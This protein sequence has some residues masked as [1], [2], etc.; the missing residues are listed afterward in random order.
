MTRVLRRLEDEAVKPLIRSSISRADRRQ[1]DV[2][3]TREGRRL[4]GRRLDQVFGRRSQTMQH[5]D[6]EGRRRLQAAVESVRK[7]ML[8]T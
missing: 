8:E 5:L 7:A 6:E 4:I 1:K 3:L 2:V